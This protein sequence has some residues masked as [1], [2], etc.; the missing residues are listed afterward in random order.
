[1]S[2]QTPKKDQLELLA[3]LE[4]AERRKK[5]C[6]ID[7]MFMDE[8][9]Y[10]REYY[11]A[12]MKFFTAGAKYS[13][14]IICAANR[15]GKTTSAGTECTYHLTGKYPKWWNGRR[16][17][18]PI[19]MWAAGLTNEL[20]RDGLQ[21]VLF[22]EYGQIGTGLI[23]KDDILEV[24]YRSNT[25]GSIDVA[26]IQHYDSQGVKDGVSA[27]GIK[28]YDQGPGK[29]QST[30]QDIIW[31]DEEP[32]GA[33]GMKIKTECLMRIAG[34]GDSE[35]GMLMMTF[36]PLHGISQVVL[37]FLPG[38]RAPINHVNPENDAWSIE[39]G[40]DDIPHI[41]KK[42]KE[43]KIKKIPLHERNA[44]TRGIASIGSGQIWPINEADVVVDWFPI[45]NDWPRVYGFDV[46]WHKTAALWAAQDP[47][48]KVWYLYDEYYVGKALTVV[49]AQAIRSKGRW[50]PGV[51]DPASRRTRDDGTSL[52]NE[53][54][55]MELDLYMAKNNI[56]TGISSIWS[57]FAEGNLKILR[58]CQNLITEI[59]LWHKDDKGRIPDLQPDHLCDC[60]K[61]LGL[62]G[63]A[64]ARV[65]PEY[66]S[67]LEQ[68]AANDKRYQG[69]SDITGY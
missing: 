23:P 24:K 65:D 68:E 47:N 2:I 57:M 3:F 35:G 48:S 50:I 19:K 32:P 61:Y 26:L 49:H 43:D 31:L 55:D 17:Y 18:R 8:G 63:F 41:S 40:W 20:T 42:E 51:V 38:G 54:L 45:P 30:F 46:G 34:V 16:W 9:P 21:T 12:F 5:Y 28:C 60:L 15:V 64:V 7:Y 25:N 69:A 4:E 52:M 22:G 1:M 66:E 10:K 62:S 27:I 67:D 33:D 14:R 44:R 29:F 59:R 36:T 6:K 37:S 53:Y 11:P 56:E 13:E 58:T 39:V